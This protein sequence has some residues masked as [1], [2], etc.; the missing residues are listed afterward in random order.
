LE[1]FDITVEEKKEILKDFLSDAN[2]NLSAIE[3]FAQKGDVE[4]IK[5]LCVKVKSSADILGLH[6]VT[7]ALQQLETVSN[8]DE[9]TKLIKTTK[10]QLDAIKSKL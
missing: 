1:N 2:Y 4:S 10:E 7:S 3:N 6:K 9:A 8:I 5:Y